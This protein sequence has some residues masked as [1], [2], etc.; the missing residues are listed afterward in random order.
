MNK[1]GRLKYIDCL[2]FFAILIIINFHLD[3]AYP[4]SVSIL[5][6]GGDIGNNLFFALSGYM[7]YWSVHE[8]DWKEIGGWYKKR[9]GKIAPAILLFSAIPVMTGYYKI[10]GIKDAFALLIF[11]TLYWFTGAIIY[12]YLI[13]FVIEKSN[14]IFLVAALVIIC[15]G[16][17]VFLDGIFLERYALGGFAMLAG[18]GLRNMIDNEII[19]L[20][21]FDDKKCILIS[22]MTIFVVSF[23]IIKLIFS[24]KNVVSIVG[25]LVVGGLTIV[26][27]LC[28][29][30]LGYLNSP[31]I[32]EL[33]NK[34]RV[35]DI[36]ITL[37]SK[38]TIYIYLVHLFEGRLL[39]VSI[40]EHLK[41]P[42]SYIVCMLSALILGVACMQ[43]ELLIRKKL[44]FKS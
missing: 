39:F 16:L 6:F 44:A 24:R 9:I 10:E 8:S 37:V 27:A 5:A 40:I 21:F 11:P 20:T 3:I 38:S 1:S 4:D 43:F 29:I 42:I 33:L 36:I 7:L 32:D 17:N 13:F 12:F 35:I 28:A 34:H 14:S 30:L 41:F 22:L 19:N 31:F 25:V 26:I 15:I 23:I 18:A 2:R